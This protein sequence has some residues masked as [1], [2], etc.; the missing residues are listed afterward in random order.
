MKKTQSG[1]TL[2]ELMIVIAIIGILASVAIPQYQVYTQRAEATAV[3]SNVRNVQLAIQEFYS[4]TGN[5]PPAIAD[6]ARY[7]VIAKTLTDISDDV[8]LIASVTVV[9][10]TADILI[11]FDT[12]T[13]GVPAGLA[14]KTMIIS[15]WA[16]N[17][18]ITFGIATASTL[19]EKYRPNL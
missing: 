9:G 5:L 8:D 2:I 7:G 6:L 11:K 16:N 15:P 10:T 17:G 14:D 12:A 1:F 19:E 4:T 3:V 13:S 18:V